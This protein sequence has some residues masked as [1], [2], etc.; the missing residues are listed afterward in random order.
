MLGNLITNAIKHHDKPEG[1]IEVRISSDDE[2][3]TLVVSGD[4]P[5]I[6]ENMREKVF[7]M[8]QTLKPRDEMEASGIGL[9]LVKRLVER[10]S[11]E[12]TVDQSASG[13]ACFTI[14]W[15]RERE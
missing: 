4:G 2:F 14:N 6:P 3:N 15:P 5:G 10:R 11:G 9:A 8:F 12:L 13:G 7:Q 1:R